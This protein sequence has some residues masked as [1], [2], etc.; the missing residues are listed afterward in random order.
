[1]IEDLDD[2]AR[3]LSLSKKEIEDELNAAADLIRNALDPDE[4]TLADLQGLTEVWKLMNRTGPE[5]KK[6]AWEQ[7]MIMRRRIVH[8]TQ[9]RMAAME[10]EVR[11]CERVMLGV[12]SL[13]SIGTKLVTI[14]C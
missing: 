3:F 6:H 12:E 7:K 13:E 9:C 11:R 10:E 14:V 5:M 8:L 4:E 1:V 2:K